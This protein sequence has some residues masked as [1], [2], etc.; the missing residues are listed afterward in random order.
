MVKVL[1]M[2]TLCLAILVYSCFSSEK[3]NSTTGKKSL[4]SY[5]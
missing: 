1:K 4:M 5:V 2:N 3:N